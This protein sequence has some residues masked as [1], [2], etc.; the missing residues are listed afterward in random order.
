VLAAGTT[1]ARNA[2]D[3]PIAE[4]PKPPA[5][6]E[7]GAVEPPAP[8]PAA[9]VRAIPGPRAHAA[10]AQAASIIAR[11]AE[12]DGPVD[13]TDEAVVTGAATSYAG[14]LTAAGGTSGSAVEPAPAAARQAAGSPPLDRARPVSLPSESWTCPWP[15]EA[16]AQQI[17]E[18]TVVL[19]VVVTASGEPESATVLADPGHGFGPAAVSCALRTRFTPALDARGRPTGATSPPIRV[20]FTR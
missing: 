15:P 9:P 19:R 7:L 3:A 4:V 17:D 14:G 13:L 2:P 18:Q 12:S 16:D 10:R 6:I 1:R 8:A 5:E 20:R 11:P